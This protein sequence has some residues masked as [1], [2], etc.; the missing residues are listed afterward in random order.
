M[1]ER[2]KSLGYCGF[3]VGW[4]R[5]SHRKCAIVSRSSEM[6]PLET[7]TLAVKSCRKSSH[8][9]IVFIAD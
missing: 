7:A 1:I 3:G 2:E 4:E 8:I 5:S 6:K 9:K